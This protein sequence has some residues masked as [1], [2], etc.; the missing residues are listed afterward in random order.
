MHIIL[1]LV[2]III[3]VVTLLV[4]ASYIV[5]RY[6]LA[7]R[8]TDA[9]AAPKSG[10]AA[11]TA[12]GIVVE[13]LAV[14]FAVALYPI[15]LIS[16]DESPSDLRPNERPVILC[17][18]YSHNSS[19]FLLM[20]RRL[21]NAGWNNLIAPSFGPVTA[22]I[23]SFA[24]KLSKLVEDILARTGCDKVDL[25]GHSMGGL[26]VRYY[27][28]SLGGSSNVATAI[29]L[30]GP[31]KGTKVAVF[32]LLQSARQFRLDSPIVAELN[33]EPAPCDSVNMISI[34]SDFD[35]VVLP[36]ENAMLPEPCGNIMVP[37]TGHL[38]LLYSSKV[39]DELRRTLST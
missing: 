18:G 26:V 28:Q 21:R 12:L 24:E 14:L 8:V 20:R 1:N 2:R 4:I 10:S 17:H 36:P 6:E 37:N 39:F 25:I 7:N 30:G 27:I 32:G 31:H 38:A 16:R 5:R 15:G 23:P 22:S 9:E 34:W 29:T 33:Q 19:A 3:I 13:I 11:E 35:S